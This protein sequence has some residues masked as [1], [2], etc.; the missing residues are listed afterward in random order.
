MDEV[1]IAGVGTLEPNDNSK[2]YSSGDSAN[3]TIPFSDTKITDVKDSHDKNNNKNTESK[4]IINKDKAL[5]P[6]K[7]KKLH[8]KDVPIPEWDNTDPFRAT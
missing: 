5:K 6:I 3:A 8:K 2:L 1:H 4:K 7:P